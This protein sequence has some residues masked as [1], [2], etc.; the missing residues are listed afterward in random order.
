MNEPP[1]T[2]S[3]EPALGDRIAALQAVADRLA[4]ALDN[5]DQPPHTLAPCAR[6]LSRVLVDIEELERPKPGETLAEALEAA[7]AKRA[8]DEAAG[9]E[10][11]VVRR[12]SRA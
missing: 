5:P 6:E 4:A 8:A 3:E 10:R 11:K 9:I 12:G 1:K 7:R 2:V